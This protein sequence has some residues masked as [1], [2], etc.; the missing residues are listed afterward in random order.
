MS[1]KTQNIYKAIETLEDLQKQISIINQLA[2]AGVSDSEGE[3]AAEKAR[4]LENIEFEM[5]QELKA[6]RF[7]VGSL[8]SING[9]STS[10][11]KQNASKENGKK[12]GR[13]PKQITEFRRRKSLLE[14]EL[15]PELQR[16]KRL[17][18]DF[19]EEN[20]IS[21]ELEQYEA[22]VE[23]INSALTEWESTK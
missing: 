4:H 1:T 13:P 16:K 8:Y 9:K 22:E 14:G 19:D 6:L 12:G 11:A 5:G 21:I 10:R 18:D 15:I 3:A 20:R 23:K 7:W 2:R 17:T